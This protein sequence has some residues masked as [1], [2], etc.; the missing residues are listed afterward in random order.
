MQKLTP[1]DFED[2]AAC[3]KSYFI[4]ALTAGQFVEVDPQIDPKHPGV[5]TGLEMIGLGF[6]NRLGY[7]IKTYGCTYEVNHSVLVVVYDGDVDGDTV[8][9]EWRR[10]Y[11][12]SNDPA[13]RQVWGWFYGESQADEIDMDILRVNPPRSII[14]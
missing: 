6:G 1:K 3:G 5:D 7:L 9:A 14:Q 10:K 8:F 13:L 11:P 12:H 4:P 2:A